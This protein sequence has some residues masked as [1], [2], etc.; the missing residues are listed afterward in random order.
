MLDGEGI[1]SGYQIGKG[2]IANAV[3]DGPE[4]HVGI[5]VSRGYRDTRDHC[6]RGVLHSATYDRIAALSE[7]HRRKT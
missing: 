1:C 6:V 7:Q 3:T 2:V 5:D 4:D